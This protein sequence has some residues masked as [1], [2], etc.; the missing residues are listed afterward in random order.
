MPAAGEEALIAQLVEMGTRLETACLFAIS[1]HD[2]ELFNRHLDKLTAYKIMFPD[3]AHGQHLEQGPHLCRRG[4]RRYSYPAHRTD[5]QPG[6]SGCAMYGAAFSGRPEVG[7]SARRG[8]PTRSG[9][10]G[11]GQNTLLRH[12]AQLL[13]YL[14]RF[15]RVGIF[16]SHC[17]ASATKP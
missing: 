14:R 13:A 12:P 6:R 3:K 7:Q 10:A 1:E 2:I 9:R 17:R 5:Y 4:T 16:P 11:A 15:E 8:A